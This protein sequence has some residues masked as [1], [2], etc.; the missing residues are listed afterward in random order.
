MTKDPS[1]THHPFRRKT[2]RKFHLSSSTTS[3]LDRGSSPIRSPHPHSRHTYSCSVS[4]RPLCPLSS[5]RLS[6]FPPA[7]FI[8]TKIVNLPWIQMYFVS[9]TKKKRPY[10]AKM[11]LLQL[12]NSHSSL[13]NSQRSS[14]INPSHNSSVYPKNISCLSPQTSPWCP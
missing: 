11:S 9:S 8:L 12:S 13:G 10:P 1:L 6:L 7:R 2:L 14:P 5:Q 4:V 3:S